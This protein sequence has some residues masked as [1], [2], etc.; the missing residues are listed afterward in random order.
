MESQSTPTTTMA[1]TL[2]DEV[3][4][5]TLDD[6]TTELANRKSTGVGGKAP[7]LAVP[8]RQVRKAPL[9]AE[10]KGRRKEVPEYFDV[11]DEEEDDDIQVVEKDPLD[12]VEV[13][14]RSAGFCDVCGDFL[15]EEEQVVEHRS[16]VHGLVREGTEGREAVKEVEVVEDQDQEI[17]V[18]ARNVARK[19]TRPP[20]APQKDVVEEK[21]EL[22]IEPETSENIALEVMQGVLDK[23]AQA[24]EDNLENR[25]VSV[26]LKPLKKKTVIKECNTEE[27]IK[28][29]TINKEYIKE[30]LVK[31]EIKTETDIVTSLE[32][33]GVS[34]KSGFLL[35]ST[36]GSYETKEVG[37]KN[38]ELEEL[39]EDVGLKVEGMEEAGVKVEG[40]DEAGV[41]VECI[42]EAG[43]KVECMGEVKRR[44]SLASPQVAKVARMA[45][46]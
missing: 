16:K 5:L 17:V 44:L 18:K 11:E 1:T 4:V 45:G 43:V 6:D 3:D 36:L 15:G 35:I 41:K 46:R 9:G 10:A 37:V 2:Q 20:R 8:F 21:E 7:H 23:V 40:M 34:T 39:G 25:N 22:E 19:S 31:S 30:E 14:D 32:K 24:V 38:E 42:D 27:I 29:E 28:E 12:D 13:Q 33:E 26:N